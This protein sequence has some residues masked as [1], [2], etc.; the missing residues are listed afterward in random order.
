MLLAIDIGNTNI[1]LALVRDGTLQPARRATTASA[2]T[3]ELE[4]L[5]ADLVGLDGLTLAGVD[6]MVVASVVPSLTV[7]LEQITTR[8]RISLLIA[9]AGTVPLAIRV[10]RPDEVGADRIVNALAA[11]RLHGT[12]AVVVDVG[13]QK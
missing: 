6:A 7:A 12:P 10:D 8:R 5:L 3:D 2:T 1:T 13:R 11:A 4:L 9:S